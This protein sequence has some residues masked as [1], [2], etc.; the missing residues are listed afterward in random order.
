M[1]TDCK[2]NNK[3]NK[4]EKIIY[5]LDFAPTNLDYLD[6]LSNISHVIAVLELLELILELTVRRVQKKCS[7]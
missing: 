7:K 1:L 4:I 5:S 3:L 2:T 6:H